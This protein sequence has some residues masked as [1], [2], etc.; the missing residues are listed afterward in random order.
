MTTA[1]TAHDAS[2]KSAGSSCRRP[3]SVSTAILSN[4]DLSGVTARHDSVTGFTV[5]WAISRNNPRAVTRLGGTLAQRQQKTI[6]RDNAN[7][8]LITK[9]EAE[10]RDP[11]TWTEELFTFSSGVEGSV[12]RSR[13][14]ILEELQ[15]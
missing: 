7:N 1:H 10:K 3:A 11:S 4:P 15:S 8:R 2:I 9:K 5:S 6:Y 13:R 14:E 12:V